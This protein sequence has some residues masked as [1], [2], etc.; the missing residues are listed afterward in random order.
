MLRT[1]EIL[2]YRVLNE[3]AQT[4]AQSVIDGLDTGKRRTCV[5]LNPHS[6]AIAERDPEFRNVVTQSTDVFC[7]GVGLSLASL[8]LNRRR[9]HRVYGYEF[10]MALSTELSAR[11]RGRVFFLGGHPDTTAELVRKYRTEFPGVAHVDFFAPPFRPEFSDEDIHD[12]AQHVDAAQT[13]ILWVGLGSP[14]QEKVLHRLM[15]VCHARCGAAIGAAFDFYTGRI[16]NAPRWMRQ[17]GLQWAHRLALEPT[18]LWRRTAISA[19][20]FLSQVLR[21][22]AQPRKR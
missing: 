17:A 19:P 22:F 12:M 4:I 18:R 14:K 7:D 21:E 11:K 20:L 5:F 6:V 15:Q 13:E 1:I 10:F 2:G 3:S 8:V 16:P 9:V